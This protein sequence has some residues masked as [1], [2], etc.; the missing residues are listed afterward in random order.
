MDTPLSRASAQ[1]QTWLPWALSLGAVAVLTIALSAEGRIWWCKHGD[2]AIYINDA[3]STHTSQHFL[4]PYSFTHILH[5]VMFFWIAALVFS[6]LSV[7]WRFLIAVVAE[8]GW[9]VLENSNW[10]IEKYRLNT[11]SLDYFGD[12]IA[13]SIGDVLC[14]ATGFWIA[15]KLGGWKSLVFFVLVEIVLLLWVRDSL[16]LNIIMLLYPFDGLKHW[17]MGM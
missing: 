7:N 10:I 12:S 6:K 16:L 1:N 13:N 4:D 14:C 5:G 2:T 3:W 15:Y 9:E 17:Q 8:A 11:A